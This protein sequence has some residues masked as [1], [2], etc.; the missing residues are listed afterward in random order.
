VAKQNNYTA[1]TVRPSVRPPTRSSVRSLPVTFE[2]HYAC[3]QRQQHR[4]RHRIHFVTE[5]KTNVRQSRERER[6]RA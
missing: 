2:K 1:Q 4:S 6:E 3:R 5:R